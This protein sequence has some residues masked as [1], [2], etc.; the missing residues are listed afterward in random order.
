VAKTNRQLVV[1]ALEARPRTELLAWSLAIGSWIFPFT[2]V[3]APLFA[4]LWWAR[5]RSDRIPTGAT[6]IAVVGFA[7]SAWVVVYFLVRATG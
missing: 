4:L 3:C 7:W 1:E 6:V 5:R 2:V